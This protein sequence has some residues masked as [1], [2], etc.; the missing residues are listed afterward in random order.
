MF[1]STHFDGQRRPGAREM[2]AMLAG[3]M[4]LNAFA[5]DSMIPALADIGKSLHVV[6]ENDRQLVVIAYF[7]GFASTQ[8][9]WGPLAD[10]F[11]RKPILAAGIA[12]YAAFAALCAFA[13][14]FP[15]LIVGR[16]AMGASA[17]VTRVLVIAMVRD[18]FEAEA[19]AR[20]MSLVFMVFMLVP[21]LAPNIGQLILLFGSWRLIFVVIAFYA[22]AMLAW[23]WARLPETLHPEFRRPLDW[24]DTLSAIAETV[25][26]PQSR[27]YT[28]ATTVS[29]SALV[30]YISS[31]QQIVFEVFGEGPRIGLVFA[32]IAAPMALGSWLNS[33]FVGRFGLRRVGHSAA[34]ALVVISAAHAAIALSGLETIW[35]FILL[36]GLTMGSFSFA[37]SN[38]GTLA[39][40]HMARIAGTA[41]SV[42][43]VVG[44]I[45]AAA[46]G[47]LI[48]QQFNG[49]L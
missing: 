47:F 14:T 16:A 15:L 35:T 31:I 43:G 39:M 37:S 13:S 17:A 20:V 6:R 8:L 32:S 2:T 28:L 49:T 23:S 4:A 46:I 21:V 42:Q 29:F 44:T 12:L 25:R 1:D 34:L 26:E 7:L 19:M 11:G 36:Q 5:I 30:A 9:V 38:F 45:G 3:L 27:G 24:R 18:L 48:G 41:S 10:R 33:R 40:E 22:L